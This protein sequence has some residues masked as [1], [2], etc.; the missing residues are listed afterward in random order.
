MT[1][2][3]NCV[4]HVITVILEEKWWTTEIKWE[5]GWFSECDWNG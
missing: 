1:I 2:I 4:K 5:N 3:Y